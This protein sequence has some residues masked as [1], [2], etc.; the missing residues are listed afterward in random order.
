MNYLAIDAAHK[1]FVFYASGG[2][3]LVFFNEF[4]F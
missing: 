2:R 3:N 4:N 1:S